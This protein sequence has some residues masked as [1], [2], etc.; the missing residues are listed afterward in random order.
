MTEDPFF[1]PNQLAPG[2][3]L[4]PEVNWQGQF[5]IKCPDGV[6]RWYT[7][8]TTFIGNLEDET[9]LRKWRE[10]KIIDGFLADPELW[11]KWLDLK[12]AWDESG[13]EDKMARNDLAQ[14]AFVAGGGED[15]SSK[16][17]FLHA[18]TYRWDTLQDTD[19]VP[20]TSTAD[21]ADL[22]SYIQLCDKAGLRFVSREQRVVIDYLKVTGTPDMVAE[23]YRCLDGKVR[24]VIADLKTGVTDDYARYGTGKDAQQLAMYADGVEYVDD[25][26]DTGVRTPFPV[27][28]SRDVG[29]ILHVP[30][31]GAIVGQKPTL[32]EV[33]LRVGRYGVGLS[34]ELRDWRNF[35]KRVFTEVPLS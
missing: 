21:D 3:V 19:N 6:S 34:K 11:A 27:E 33:N 25:G 16:G 12:A 15:A 8:C 18:L 1:T 5:R 2:E 32:Y 10:R 26:S 13:V 7:R 9:L 31:G 29:L 24:N 23:G 17:T 4:E 14:M 22:R 35:S 20:M 28:V 30:Q